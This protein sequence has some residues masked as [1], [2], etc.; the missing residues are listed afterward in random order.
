MSCI[1]EALRRAR[2]SGSAGEQNEPRAV[3]RHSVE[4]PIV[5]SWQLDRL[6]SEAAAVDRRL[7]AVP[8]R[9]AAGVE[10]RG[11]ATAPRPEPV[12]T[13][14]R[15]TPVRY[16]C[17]G[18]SPAFSEKLMVGG[19]SDAASAEQYRRV[20]ALLHQAQ[21]HHG[22]KS[23]MV[24]SALPGEGKTLTAANLALTLSESYGRRVLLVDADLRRPALHEIFQVSN[25]LGL[26]DGLTTGADRPLPLIEFSRSL[27]VLPAGPPQADPM[28]L[29]ASEG[30]R[31][32]LAD[33]GEAF[34]W[35]VV[36]TPPLG[37]VTD[38]HLLSE[39]V[40]KVV[41]VV[42]ATVTPHEEVTA[43]ADRIGRERIIG[44]VLNGVDERDVTHAYD[45]YGYEYARR[46]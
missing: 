17:K 13:S 26:V 9:E 18:V 45:R 36:D 42:R 15:T 12:H 2:T 22:I 32:A 27:C 3:E 5:P 4:S 20:G 21:K 44:V 10:P 25:A 1:D 31:R 19:Q 43:A 37:V 28:R 6:P 34:D 16:K 14:A 11:V 38:A 46:S 24:A 35:V 39:I 7:T 41:L 8:R 40:D 29:L 23:V 30:M 33:A